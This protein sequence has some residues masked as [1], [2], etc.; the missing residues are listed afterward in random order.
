MLTARRAMREAA[1][2]PQTP[3][4]VACDQAH[5]HHI[6][7]GEGSRLLGRWRFRCAVHGWTSGRVPW[8]LARAALAAHVAV[9]EED[10][11]VCAAGC[12]CH[13]VPDQEPPSRARTAARDRGR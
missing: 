12:S 7:F 8:K 5:D 3:E 4:A 11:P 1:A 10:P 6:I 2:A 9:R 13:D